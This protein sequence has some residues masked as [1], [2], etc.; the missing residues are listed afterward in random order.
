[1]RA[2][3]P[4]PQP[5]GPASS[6]MLPLKW[7]A[8]S[9]LRM[10]T[11]ARLLAPLCRLSHQR[12]RGSQLAG[13]A[14]GTQLM[15]PTEK[16]RVT[17]RSVLAAGTLVNPA[18]AAGAGTGAAVAG[19]ACAFTIERHALG[20]ASVPTL[21]AAAEV[22][23]FIFSFIRARKGCKLARLSH[24]SPPGAQEERDIHASLL[25]QQHHDAMRVANTRPPIFQ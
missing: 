23:K 5:S 20:V 12:L 3:L 17:V 16:T 25:L 24:M 8:A 9:L 22:C 10:R 21:G 15:A 19:A 14:Q 1:M 2:V 7:A 6:R 13:L 11:E 18:A 4:L